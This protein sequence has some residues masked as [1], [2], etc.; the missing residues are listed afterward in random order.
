MRNICPYLDQERYGRVGFDLVQK[1]PRA[2]RNKCQDLLVGER[3][4][5]YLET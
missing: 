4:V 3:Y 1:W 2:A 5:R